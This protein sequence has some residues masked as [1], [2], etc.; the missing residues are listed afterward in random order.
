MSSHARCVGKPGVALDVR[1]IASERQNEANDRKR[2]QHR[3]NGMAADLWPCFAGGRG[4]RLVDPWIFSSS[5]DSDA[6]T[7]EMVP[8]AIVA[9]A[10]RVSGAPS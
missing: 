6:F 8:V 4:L 10:R 1:D 2:D 9:A 5:G 3:V 7:G